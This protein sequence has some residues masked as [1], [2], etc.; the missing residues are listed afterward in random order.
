MVPVR[1]LTRTK[2]SK[3]G[4]ARGESRAPSVVPLD[5]VR[6]GWAGM[7]SEVAGRWVRGEKANREMTSFSRGG[8]FEGDGPRARVEGKDPEGEAKE[9]SRQ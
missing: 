1:C 2:P 7:E 4:G 3:R 9:H 6:D 5:R 8:P